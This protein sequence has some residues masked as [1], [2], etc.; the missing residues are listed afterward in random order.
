MITASSREAGRPL[1]L[2]CALLPMGRGINFPSQR[3]ADELGYLPSSSMMR[4]CSHS[5]APIA[6]EWPLFHSVKEEAGNQF[7]ITKNV[8]LVNFSNKLLQRLP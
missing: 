6:K 5:M 1:A 2:P 4:E 7:K 8:P 3:Y